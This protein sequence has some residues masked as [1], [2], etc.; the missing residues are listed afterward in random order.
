[1]ARSK[2]VGCGANRFEVVRADIANG[3][4]DCAL[5][6]CADCGG[7]VGARDVSTA[8]TT[9]T[10]VAMADTIGQHLTAFING[11]SPWSTNVGNALIR[12]DGFLRRRVDNP[13]GTKLEP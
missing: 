12:I 7:V 3:D 2:C 5:I 13:E 1:M 8:N 9:K 10:I 11:F 4:F 6:Q